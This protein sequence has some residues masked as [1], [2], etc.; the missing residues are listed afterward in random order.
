MTSLVVMMYFCQLLT[1]TYYD[2]IFMWDSCS[3][4]RNIYVIISE[5]TSGMTEY[6]MG[7]IAI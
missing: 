5:K 6:D 2:N 7:T 3:M 4:P 1:Y